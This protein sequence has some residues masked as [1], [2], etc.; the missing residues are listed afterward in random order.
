MGNTCTSVFDDGFTSK[1][2]LLWNEHPN[3]QAFHVEQPLCNRCCHGFSFALP[4]QDAE[5]S[6][7]TLG[8]PIAPLMKLF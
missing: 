6:E 1:Q 7:M 5:V 8:H 3:T 4:Q 2:T